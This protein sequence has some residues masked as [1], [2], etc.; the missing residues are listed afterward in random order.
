MRRQIRTRMVEQKYIHPHYQHVDGT[1]MAAPVVSSVVAQ[2]LE[3][4]PALTPAQ[5]KEILMR[6]AD[7]L[8]GIPKK[9]QGAG[10][11]NAARA[12]AVARRVSGGPLH[13]LPTSPQG[14]AGR[15]TVYYYDPACR[16]ARVALVGAFNHWS[17]K[18]YDLQPLST[19]LWRISFPS[20]PTGSY[21]Y[22]FLV[23]DRWEVDIENPDRV[24]DGYGGFSSVL[25]VQA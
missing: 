13:G 18:G 21:R 2:L 20:P 17:P 3:A 9:Q 15:I 25:K 19:G 11:I 24:E 22:K 23:D 4:C 8:A 1:S 12:V 7:P 6:T 16:A 10:V 14:Q 5:V